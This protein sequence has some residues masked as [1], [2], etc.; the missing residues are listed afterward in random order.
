MVQVFEQYLKVASLKESAERMQRE[1]NGDGSKG[2]GAGQ[3]DGGD[4]PEIGSMAEG[5]P[6]LKKQQSEENEADASG[7]LSPFKMTDAQ[8]S[9]GY[10]SQPV[11][12]SGANSDSEN[13]ESQY[14]Q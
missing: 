1:G 8:K 13:Q 10:S 7:K 14:K 11:I 5:A 12:P 2:E 6:A 9:M 4:V 3:V